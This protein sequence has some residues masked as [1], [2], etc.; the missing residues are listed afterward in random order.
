MGFRFATKAMTLDDHEHQN[1]GFCEFFWRF[2]TVR[3]I[4]RANC[5]EI[6]RDRQGQA[7]HEIFSIEC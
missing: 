4:S 3:L 1:R 6:A 5:A 7:P 2:C